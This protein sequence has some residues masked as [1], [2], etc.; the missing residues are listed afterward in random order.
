MMAVMVVISYLWKE[1][2]DPGWRRW[3]GTGLCGFTVFLGGL[4]WE[5]FGVFVLIIIA[6]EFWKFCTTETEADLKEYFL[7]VLMFVP[8]LLLISPAYRGGYGF[9]KHVA[10]LLLAPPLVLLALRGVRYMLC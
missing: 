5:G 8:G 2:T 9:S 6:V 7:W 4:S 3:L 10:F 1:R